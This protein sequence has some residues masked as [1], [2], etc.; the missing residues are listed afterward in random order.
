VSYWELLGTIE[1]VTL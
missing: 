1:C